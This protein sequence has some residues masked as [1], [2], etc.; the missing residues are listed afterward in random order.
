MKFIGM[1]NPVPMKQLI[2]EKFNWLSGALV[3]PLDA[4]AAVNSSKD[5]W[6]LIIENFKRLRSLVADE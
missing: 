3:V 1:V 6:G 5:I 4:I 2:F